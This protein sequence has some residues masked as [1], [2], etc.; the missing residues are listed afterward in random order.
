MMYA[1][2]S[3]SS[4][5]ARLP[6][7]PQ[8]FNFVIYVLILFVVLTP[9]CLLQVKVERVAKPSYLLQPLSLES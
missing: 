9:D 6:R 2:P 7:N 4:S 1:G 8:A 3:S 5:I